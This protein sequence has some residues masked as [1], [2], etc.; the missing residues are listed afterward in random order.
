MA[1]ATAPS[2]LVLGRADE[3]G[4]E[5][6][7]VVEG[8]TPWPLLWAHATSIGVAV[9][10][11]LVVIVIVELAFFRSG[12]F[13]SHVT[14]SDPDFPLGKLALAQRMPDAQVLYVGDSTINT[15]IAPAVV[16][17]E[18]RCGPGFNGAI[19]ASTPWL[20]T[21]MTRHLLEIEHPRLV[22]IGVGPWTADSARR[23]ADSEI[24]HEVLRPDEYTTLGQ[25]PNLLS[26]MDTAI[27]EV[28][29]AYGQRP[30]LK[31]WLASWVPGHAYD[32]T[33][34][35]FY[36][37][38]GSFTSPAQLGA[39]L[40]KL[41]PDASTE[42][43]SSAPGLAVTRELIDEL[44]ARGIRVAIVL[45]PLHPFAYEQRGPYLDRAN[46]IITEFAAA[47]GAAVLDCRGSVGP[48]DF[49]DL[50]H[51]GE[52]GAIKFSRCLGDQ[53]GGLVQR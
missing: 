5:S 30:V 53:L 24:A 19:G 8:A 32:M 39:A 18:C 48:S 22:V 45:P 21:A 31:E 4:P 14:L 50:V 1:R 33:K 11:C 23:F 49:R 41:D 47:E 52:T 37:Y 28:W 25:P 29:S 16:T 3:V 20:T 6:R 7:E 51:L 46:A 9:A 26:R 43:S 12:F 27:G 15:G 2:V 40:A 35:G 44:R 42:L 34:R 38:P 17:E 10:M 36:P 13:M